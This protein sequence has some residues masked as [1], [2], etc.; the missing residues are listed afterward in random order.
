MHKYAQLTENSDSAIYLDICPF[1]TQSY[2]IVIFISINMYVL[3]NNVIIWF[4]IGVCLVLSKRSSRVDAYICI[5]FNNGCPNYTYYS[6]TIYKRKY[7]DI[8]FLG[9]PFEGIFNKHSFWAH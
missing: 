1:W 6:N 8:F 9:L 7:F 5:E 3:M 4:V 2:N